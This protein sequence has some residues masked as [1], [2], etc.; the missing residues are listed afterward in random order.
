MKVLS[1]NATLDPVAG[2]GTAER[3]FQ[4]S[5]HLALAGVECSVLTLDLGLQPERIADLRPST[6]TALHCTV[7]RY[8]LFSLPEGQYPDGE[9]KAPFPHLQYLRSNV[10]C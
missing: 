1:V 2:G 4:L 10:W 7:P 6:V 5:R 8:F 9:L 3:T